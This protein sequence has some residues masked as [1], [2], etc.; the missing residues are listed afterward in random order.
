LGSFSEAL[1]RRRPFAAQGS[2]RRRPGRQPPYNAAPRP[3]PAGGLPDAMPSPALPSPSTLVER[4]A[5]SGLRGRGGGWFPAVRKWRAVAVEGGRPFVVANGAEGEP[6]SFK[7][8]YVMEKRADLVV[9]G[10][11]LAAHALRAS[12]AVV[13][14]K[15]SFDRP[16]EAL[17]RAIGAADLDGLSIAVQRGDD[18]YVAGEETA[19]LEALEGR[20]A[21]PR[22]KPPLPAAVGFE[23]RPTLVHN[24]E[25]L[26]RV[27]AAI[28][29]PEAFRRTETTFV[30][31]WGDVRRPGVHEVRLGT[32]LAGLVEAAGGATE[33]VGLVF[34]AGPAAPRRSPRDSPR[35]RA[36]R[37]AGY[38]V[39]RRRAARG[40]RFGLSR[41]RLRLRPRLLRARELRA[42][43]AVHGGRRE[44]C[45]H[46]ARPRGRR[47]AAARSPRSP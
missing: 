19:V 18:S 6:G 47:R 11:R 1:G 43:P 34:P 36:A 38:R 9:E 45:P 7:D 23:G 30:T 33:P 46:R 29:D 37:R 17:E 20:R 27:P 10:I 8:R 4:L 26:S 24:V 12:E 40:G 35:P 42:V 41:R 39:R 15:A 14:L 31:V 13:F 32:P 28:A 2:P 5:A 22:P 25:T 3:S 44:P 21:W 16:A